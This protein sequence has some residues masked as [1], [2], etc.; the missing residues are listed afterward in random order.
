[1]EDKVRFFKNKK[2]KTVIKVRGEN[3]LKQLIE[4]DVF[5]ECLADGNDLGKSKSPKAKSEKVEVKDENSK[6]DS[7]ATDETKSKADAL[8][9]D[10]DSNIKEEDLLVL[11]ELTESD[12]K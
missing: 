5:T 11:I 3:T 12:N 8:K 1:M 2:G 7:K 10:Y 4:S 9:I 6:V